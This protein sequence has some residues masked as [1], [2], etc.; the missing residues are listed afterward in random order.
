MT[1]GSLLGGKYRLVR[2]IGEGAMGA[3]WAAVNLGTGREVALKLIQRPTEHLRKRLEREARAY[4]KLQHRNVIEVFDKGETA[5]GDPFLVM[6]LL[7]GET[8]KARIVR[9]GKFSPQLAA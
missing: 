2:Q 6:P 4:G 7:T 8:L 3:G 1:P 5:K 9:E